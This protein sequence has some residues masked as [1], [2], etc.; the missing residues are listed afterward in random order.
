MAHVFAL[1]LVITAIADAAE[2]KGFCND[3]DSSCANWAKNGEC[4]GANAEHLATLCPH[5]CAT[6]TLACEDKEVACKDWALKGEC[7]KNPKSM[8]S[9]CPTSCGLCTPACKDWALKGECKKN[10]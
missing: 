9:L 8:F 1:V 7:K 4:T 5:S 10:P 3:R 2:L 6:C